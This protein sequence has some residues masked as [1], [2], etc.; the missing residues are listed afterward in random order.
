VADVILTQALKEQ[1][2]TIVK[3]LYVK[4]K[5]R[6]IGVANEAI[7]ELISLA[8]AGAAA[9][10][11]QYVVYRAY[12]AIDNLRNLLE[13]LATQGMLIKPL[14]GNNL[15]NDRSLAGAR[16]E[17]NRMMGTLP[18]KPIAQQLTPSLVKNSYEYWSNLYGD[19]P[20]AVKK[21]DEWLATGGSAATLAKTITNYS[22]SGNTVSVTYSDGTKGKWDVS[23]TSSMSDLEATLKKEINRLGSIGKE[24][25]GI[26]LYQFLGKCKTAAT[27]SASK[28]TSTGSGGG[29]T[30]TSP[31][32]TVQEAPIVTRIVNKIVPLSAPIEEPPPFPPHR[33]TGSVPVEPFVTTPDSQTWRPERDNPKYSRGTYDISDDVMSPSKLAAI[34]KVDANKY[35]LEVLTTIEPTRLITIENPTD[36]THW[37]DDDTWNKEVLP[38]ELR[39]GE[40]FEIT[41]RRLHRNPDKLKVLLNE[42]ETI[43]Q[44]ASNWPPKIKGS[45]DWEHGGEIDEWRYNS[46]LPAKYDYQIQ[47]DDPRLAY[48]N[49]LETKL[50]NA[51]SALGIPVHGSNN[52]AKT[53]RYYLYNR[54]KSPDTN[55]A[56]NKSFTY[57]FFT[58]P[59]LNILKKT[60]QTADI[61]DQCL[62]H[63]ESTMLWYRNPALFKLL[64]DRS[65]CGDVDNFNMLL[66]NACTNFS[67]EDE[68]LSFIEVGRSWHDYAIQYGDS[69]SG[70]TAGQI[71]VNFTDDKYYSVVNQIKLWITYIDNVARGAWL[72]SYN[73]HN[74]DSSGTVLATCNTCR[75]TFAVVP[76]TT[77][78]A[79]C[80][81]CRSADVN[82][83]KASRIPQ[84]NDSHV[85]TRTLDYAAS[86]Y[87]FKVGEDGSDILY[88]SKYYGLFPINTGASA[89]SW[90]LTSPPG[91]APKLSINFRYAFKRDMS[92]VSLI[93]FN[94]NANATR[95]RAVVP[96]ES[97]WAEGYNHSN[98]PYVG[99]PY[100]ELQLPQG[101]PELV[102]NAVNDSNQVK[103]RLKFLPQGDVIGGDMDKEL[104]RTRR[105]AGSNSE[106]LHT[107]GGSRATLEDEAR[108]LI[109][110]MQQNSSAWHLA[111]A[112]QRAWLDARNISIAGQLESLGYSG[113]RRANGVWYYGESQ[114]YSM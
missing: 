46:Y 40:I 34:K 11:S 100:V 81:N 45:G 69:Y 42:D 6:S 23:N 32:T 28:T 57:V 33:E 99:T 96:S 58:R 68:N 63:T 93:E 78:N 37:R 71:T 22:I 39:S 36:P 16:S 24:T 108:N 80:P 13:N 43:I 8:K 18:L 86:A 83:G 75:Y 51:R 10:A 15:V 73:L 97:P 52:L 60:G 54:F 62:N 105:N 109:T 35:G 7:A 72:P 19:N 98:R 59:D 89:L 20:T 4:A 14:T 82:V 61:A 50:M 88:W 79:H 74:I 111:D 95:D 47:I 27:A 26:D 49:S 25:E 53:M 101:N 94:R 77:I 48:A 38:N 30:T 2:D 113:I 85:Y 12:V 9:N 112:S 56:H 87:V 114:L 29:S 1:A 44:N 17:L 104:F 91:E 31:T 106:Y 64:V 5:G 41:S 92:P 90:E 67:V 84:P 55:L 76:T 3:N 107:F 110:E 21:W 66:S 65:R 103:L 102:P 70:R